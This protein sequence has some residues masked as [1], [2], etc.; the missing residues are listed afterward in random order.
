MQAYKIR[1]PMHGAW[2][3]VY[4]LRCIGVS[5]ECNQYIFFQREKRPPATKRRFFRHKDVKQHEGDVE[6]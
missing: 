4:Y 2:L 5:V 1:I 6:D 3:G